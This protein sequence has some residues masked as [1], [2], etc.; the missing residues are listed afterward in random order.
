MVSTELHQRAKEL[1]R[2]N[3]ASRYNTLSDTEKEIMFRELVAYFDKNVDRAKNAVRMY[4]L[5]YAITPQEAE[6]ALI[7]EESSD[8]VWG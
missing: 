1:E 4:E 8:H 7:K 6:Q 2:Q 3:Q 5:G